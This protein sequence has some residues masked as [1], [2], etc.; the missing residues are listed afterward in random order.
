GARASVLTYFGL[1]GFAFMAVEIALMQR[2]TLFLGHP[3]YSLLVILFV[4]LLATATG[5]RISER[6]ADA[7]LPKVMLV[8]GIAL[9]V[10]TIIYGLVLGDVLRAL[11]GLA[12]PVR[13][14]LTGILVAPCG[15]LM[16][17]MIPSIIRVLGLANSPLV[18][19]GWGVNGATSVIGTSIATIVAMY[20]GFTATF[21]VGAITYA[22]AGV[23]G[24]SVGR[25]YLR[26]ATQ[27]R[28]SDAA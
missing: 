15:L 1:V 18:P 23:L 6:F 13:I 22:A 24:L 12:R 25:S 26:R 9:G 11:I 8:A 28:A 27:V 4:V 16:G 7:Q 5:S 17:V 2:F 21:F 10:L 14:I 20:V 3:T 19:W